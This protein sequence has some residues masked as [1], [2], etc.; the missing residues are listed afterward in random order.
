MKDFLNFDIIAERVDPAHVRF[1]LKHR[2]KEGLSLE[3]ITGNAI[4]NQFLPKLF[5]D[6]LKGWAK[7]YRLASR[8]HMTAGQKM[9]YDKL[10][11]F[12]RNY[13]R[14]PSYDEMCVFMGFQSK[15]T[16]FFYVRKLI[17]LGW[18]WKDDKGLVI[19]IDIAPAD[20]DS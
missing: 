11:D 8:G 9:F 14:A 2:I 19:P 10:M 20:I 15:G 3:F 4:D 6:I 18:C 5:A 7:K 17:E 16:P 13:N 1:T 12:H